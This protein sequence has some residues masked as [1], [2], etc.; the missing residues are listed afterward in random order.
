[1]PAASADPFVFACLV[2]HPPVL[3][4]AVGR[5]REE[6][7]RATCEAFGEIAQTLERAHADTLLLICPHGPVTLQRFHILT[8]RLNGDLS[9]FDA[10]DVAFDIE[11]DEDLVHAIGAEADKRG[12]P[13]SEVGT[14]EFHDHSA[15]VP[16]SFLRAAAPRAKVVAI[17]ISFLP[18]ADHLELGRAIATAAEGLGRRIAIVGSADGSHT[19]AENGPY[20]FHPAGPRFEQEYRQALEAWDRETLLDFD[21]Q[22]RR[23]AG[24]DC[25]P[26]LSILMGILEGRAVRPRVLSSEAPWG[27]GYLAALVDFDDGPGQAL[28]AAAR[29]A[30]EVYASDGGRRLVVEELAMQPPALLQRKA[31]AFVSIHARAGALR[32]CIG[33]TSPS[34]DSLLAEVLRNAVAAASRDPRFSPIAASELDQLVYKVDVLS[35]PEPIDGPDALDPKRFGVIVEEQGG[36]RRGILL[37]DLP[38]IDDVETQIEITR[39]KAGIPAGAAYALSRFRVERYEES[40]AD[41]IRGP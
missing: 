29:R 34:E 16:L 41:A 21:D 2:P 27:V 13:L 39:D 37:P 20:G 17:S 26:T 36:D 4:P 35:P 38:E 8:G 28:L 1:M 11:T 12:L 40:A 32:G 15:W 9:R 3:V 14:W 7:A 18:A 19:L 6:G 23:D 5:G 30:V 31:A 24:E 10:A 33:T 22:Y 25:V